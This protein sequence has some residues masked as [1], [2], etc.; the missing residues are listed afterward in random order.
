MFTNVSSSG[1]T[2]LR[3]QKIANLCAVYDLRVENG[4]VVVSTAVEKLGDP[5]SAVKEL[6]NYLHRWVLFIATRWC[7]SNRSTKF[8]C[9]SYASGAEDLAAYTYERGVGTYFLGGF[10][11]ATRQVKLLA[12]TAAFASGPADDLNQAL[13]N[14][15][16]LLLKSEEHREAM[17]DAV[18]Y[19]Q[20]LDF[21]VFRR[22]AQLIGP[23][24]EADDLVHHVMHCAFVSVGYMW[25]LL[26]RQL[27]FRPL[28]L[29][30]G[31]IEDNV[32][33][34]MTADTASLDTVSKRLQSHDNAW[35][36]SRICCLVFE[37]LAQ[38][39]L[40]NKRGG[41]SPWHWRHDYEAEGP[42]GGAHVADNVVDSIGKDVSNAV[43]GGS[44][45]DAF[46]EAGRPTYIPFL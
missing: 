24:F 6:I 36:N 34:L 19:L 5:R 12:A 42:V 10:R 26:F 35:S 13:F 2:S 15:D 37:N 3:T 30:Q 46:G 44:E 32:K 29:T 18:V 38:S 8:L 40:H 16:R 41:A 43:Q 21:Y 14:D 23:D 33:N 11:K 7:S 27:L 31:N 1:T 17:E 9:R 45:H 20:T 22:V 28:S 25:Y 4:N 39:S